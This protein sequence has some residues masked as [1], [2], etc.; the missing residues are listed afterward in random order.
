VK[1]RMVWAARVLALLWAA[2][3]LFFFVA[4][5]WACGTPALAAAPWVGAG[6]LFAVL[7]LAPRRWEAAGGVLLVAL[8]LTAGT[9]YAIWAPMWRPPAVRAITIAVLGAPPLVSGILF[10]RHRRALRSSP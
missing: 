2:F 9:A 5:S 4:E 3:W 1:L 8:G 6:L 10:L 7:A